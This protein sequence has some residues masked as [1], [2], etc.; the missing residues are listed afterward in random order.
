MT[1]SP[2]VL[3]LLGSAAPPVLDIADVV[4]RAQADGWSVCVGLTTTAAEWLEDRLPALE[5]QTGNP[6]RSAVRKPADVEVWPR[7]DV[8]VLAP[9][10]LNTVNVAALGL[11]PHFVGGYVAE[12]IGK[13]W[14]LVVM[15]CVN[16]AYATHPQ[17]G[18]SIETLRG[19][20]VRVL[21]GDGGF[22]P[23]PPGQGDT[24]T[25]PWHLALDTA[26]EAA[27]T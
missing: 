27:R 1:T 5:E 2:S 24:A 4:R 22:Q 21:Y 18:R 8:A 6:V 17:F 11:T 19:A 12:A 16:S 9:A 13:R 10:T 3:Y 23:K 26:A 20:G 14:P 15:P 7:A 25:Y